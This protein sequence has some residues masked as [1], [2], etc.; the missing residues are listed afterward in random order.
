MRCIEKSFFLFNMG[1]SLTTT[2]ILKEFAFAC[3]VEN[4]TMSVNGLNKVGMMCIGLK[5]APK[6]V[7]LFRIKQ[8]TN[9]QGAT[10][11]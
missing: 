9:Q 10:N 5:K 4:L 6:L 11:G 7:C 3:Y 1:A 8:R 2:A